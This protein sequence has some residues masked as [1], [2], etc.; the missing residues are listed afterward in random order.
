MQLLIVPL[1]VLPDPAR[2]AVTYSPTSRAMQ[3]QLDMQLLILPLAVLSQLDM[4]L[5][6]VSLAMLPVPARYAVTYSPTSCATRPS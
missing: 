3:S 4:Q 5:L 1:A 6:I 2:Y